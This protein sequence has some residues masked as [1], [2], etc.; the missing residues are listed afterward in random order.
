MSNKKSQSYLIFS[1]FFTFF[2]VLIEYRMYNRINRKSQSTCCIKTP[3]NRWIVIQC[4][5]NRIL[6]I[7]NKW[8]VICGILCCIYIISQS[9]CCK[10]SIYNKWNVIC[11]VFCCICIIS[12]ST[13]C[14][15]IDTLQQ[16]DCDIMY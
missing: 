5:K 13:C 6:S 14:K 15:D 12:Q 4:T 10:M 2:I 1:V 8:I 16:V 3:Y 11:G 9:I 7:Y